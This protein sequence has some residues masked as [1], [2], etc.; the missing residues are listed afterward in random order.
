MGWSRMCLEIRF[1]DWLFKLKVKIAP[2]YATAMNPD[3]NQKDR[4]DVPDLDPLYADQEEKE[5]ASKKEEIK[6]DEN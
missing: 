1:S 5:D 6:R 3:R 2:N 4:K